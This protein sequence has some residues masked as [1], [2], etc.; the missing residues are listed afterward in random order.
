MEWN[1]V[2]AAAYWVQTLVLVIPTGILNGFVWRGAMTDVTGTSSEP[3][4]D[5][6]RIN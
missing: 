2:V 3:G 5:N 4:I 6:N 1:D